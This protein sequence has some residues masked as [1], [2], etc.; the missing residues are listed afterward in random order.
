MKNLSKEQIQE[1]VQAAYGRVARE[2]EKSGSCGCGCGEAAGLDPRQYAKALGYSEEELDAIPSGANLA[3]SCGNPNALAGLKE[4]ETVLDLGSGAGFDCFLAA[5]R[6]GPSGKVI[7]VDMTTEML[8]KAEA[9]ARKSGITNVEFRRGEIEALP[10]EDESVDAVISNCVINLSAD[11]EAVFREIRRVLRPGGRAAISDI[12]LLKEL[13]APVLESIAAYTGCVGGA[14][15]AAEYK[16]MMEAAGLRDVTVEPSATG[17]CGAGDTGD[18]IA[19]AL[20]SWLGSDT[21]L[22]E[23]IASAR[24]SARK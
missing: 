11:K 17:A 10:V 9:N 24:I 2:S 14:V 5:D 4:G 19:G 18:P 7:G 21:N 15:E 22:F 3:L 8:E 20:T 1:L 13:P 6:V 23:Y 16:R 12:V